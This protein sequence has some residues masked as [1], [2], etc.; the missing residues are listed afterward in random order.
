M[1]SRYLQG[2]KEGSWFHKPASIH[3]LDRKF[4]MVIYNTV[5]ETVVYLRLCVCLSFCMI[6]SYILI[7]T[8]INITE[9]YSAV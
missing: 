4:I 9:T 2:K 3:G 1:S 6:V 5:L 8:L 7:E